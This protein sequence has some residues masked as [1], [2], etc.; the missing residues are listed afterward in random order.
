MEFWISTKYVPN[1]CIHWVLKMKVECRCNIVFCENFVLIM[2]SLPRKSVVRLTDRPDMTLDVYRG[3]KTTK[4]KKKIMSSDPYFTSFLFSGF[5][6][7]VGKPVFHEINMIL[8]LFCSPSCH[9]YSV[10]MKIFSGKKV[11]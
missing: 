7:A 5:H 11:H 1:Q 8:V 9:F 4:Q 3:R 10:L 6:A 2:S